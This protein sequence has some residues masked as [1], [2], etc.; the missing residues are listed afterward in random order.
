MHLHSYTRE[1]YMLQVN[2]LVHAVHRKHS[3]KNN[4]L[5]KG[6]FEGDNR[7]MCTWTFNSSILVQ[8]NRLYPIHALWSATEPFV[9]YFLDTHSFLLKICTT[10]P[11]S[12]WRK[13]TEYTS[14]N[15]PITVYETLRCTHWR[16]I[17]TGANT[18]NCWICSQITP[19][20]VNY[21]CVRVFLRLYRVN[22]L[23]TEV[24]Y[25]V[26][27]HKQCFKNQIVFAMWRRNI[28]FIFLGVLLVMAKIAP[29]TNNFH[30]TVID[31]SFQT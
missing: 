29:K 8:A 9:L 31:F 3:Y 19:L 24:G 11:Y 30:K 14:T 4:T 2:V 21:V 28:L 17:V 15:K 10:C 16:R 12:F 22:K 25:N 6:L 18:I 27:Y 26:F 7:S 13:F 5:K 20:R 1:I 23:Y